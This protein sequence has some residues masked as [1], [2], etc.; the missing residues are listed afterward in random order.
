MST[1]I[2]TLLAQYRAEE[3]EQLEHVRHLQRQMRDA[4]QK[5]AVIS[6]RIQGMAEALELVK[7]SKPIEPTGRTRRKGKA[8]RSRSLSGHWKEIMRAVDIFT[9]VD[10]YFDYAQ[11]AKA[12]ASVGQDPSADTLRSQMSLYKQ[13]GLVEPGAR[14]GTFRLT[15]EGRKAAGFEA[16]NDKA[17][18]AATPEASKF[19]PEAELEGSQAAQHPAANRESV[20]SNPTRSAPLTEDWMRTTSSDP[21]SPTPSPWMGGRR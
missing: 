6:A 9:L 17:S 12:A 10:G 5:L 21:H 11:L 19:G 14:Q 2:E 4:E 1:E 3:A 7:A 15:D 8:I 20:G 18:G 13:S 16:S